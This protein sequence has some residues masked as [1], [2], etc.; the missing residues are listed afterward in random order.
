MEGKTCEGTL[1]EKKNRI[2]NN[3]ELAEADS[4]SYPTK[5]AQKLTVTLTQR[6]FTLL[7]REGLLRCYEN[8][9]PA[10]GKGKVL[11]RRN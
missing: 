5:T 4:K 10:P 1:K 8:I 2:K 11:A 9:F 3:S 7:V 6:I